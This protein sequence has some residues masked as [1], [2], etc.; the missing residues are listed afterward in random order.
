MPNRTVPTLEELLT[1]NKVQQTLR[2]TEVNQ[3]LESLTAQERVEWAL[4]NLQGNHALSSSFGIQAAVMLHL[5]TSVKSDIPVVLTDTGYL[6][7]ET[8]QFIDELTERLKLN[9]KVYSAPVSSA[10]QE[11]RY[12]KL[13]EQ[14][15]EGIERYN[16]INK[17]EP[18][19]RALNE[20]NI[21]TWFSGLRREQSQSRASLPI[22]SVQN[23]VFK[24]LPVIDWNNKEVHYYL[25][26]HDLPYHPLWE[27]GYLSVGDTHTTQKWQ[28]GMSEE[29][30]RFFG[31]KRECGL[32]EDNSEHQ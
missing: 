16:Q 26:D 13:W 28:P 12:G 1:L 22:L 4:E 31:L 21:G 5:L 32:H 18:M 6:F 27:Q 25:K 24:F 7:P 11:A 29:Q 2:L 9:V 23:G 14:G 10:W 30:T 20:L 19:R 15:V 17:V 8:Y 3:Q